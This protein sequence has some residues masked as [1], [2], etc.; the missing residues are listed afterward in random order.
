[1]K[2]MSTKK[3]YNKREYILEKSKDI[4]TKKGF[5]SV[6]MTDII[7]AC[8]ISRGGLYLYFSSVDE[9]FI[10]MI[11]SINAQKLNEAK[12]SVTEDK[13]FTELI[14]IY[15][16]KQKNRILNIDSSLLM[17]MHQYRFTHKNDGDEMFFSEQFLNTKMI[18]LEL[19]NYGIH[20]NEI[21]I[22]N[23]ENLAVHIMLFIEGLSTLA[24]TST[25]SEEFIDSQIEF[26]KKLIFTKNR[27]VGG[28]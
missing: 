1:M 20:T 3:I 2:K 18:L 22:E 7:D 26:I 23:T 4:F 16:E 9:I 12:T 24:A 25:P 14:D 5:T 27:N 19:L 15:F 8:D 13:T 17:A 21:R 6:T 10:E 28:L 11:L